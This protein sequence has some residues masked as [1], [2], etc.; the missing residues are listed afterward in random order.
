M[1]RVR[2]WAARLLWTA[3]VAVGAG[4]GGADA[5]ADAP[6]G[7]RFSQPTG[8]EEFRAQARRVPG[9]PLYF[10]DGDTPLQDD[11]EL[12]DFYDRYVR[13]GALTINEDQGKP[14]RWGEMQK[15]HLTYCVSTSF[16]PAHD[17][18]AQELQDAARAWE[19][20]AG[21]RFVHVAS[22]DGT[23]TPLNPHVVF[24]VRPAPFGTDPNI[25]AA[26]FFPN[27]VRGSRTV[28]LNL[29]ARWTPGAPP[30]ETG[31]LRHELGHV[32]GFR[33]EHVRP[34]AGGLCP[35]VHDWL[36]L[37]P[38]DPYSVMHYPSCNGRGDGWLTLTEEDVAGAREVYGPPA[39][40]LPD[41]PDTLDTSGLD[42]GSPQ[43]AQ[44]WKRRCIAGDR[45]CLERE[46]W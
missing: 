43:P 39:T 10:V 42:Q 30:T 14:T 37:T 45:E 31:V 7:P 46:S 36:P 40:E 16:G 12:R 33:H 41:T 4:C 9:S 25:Y 19:G 28:W 5:L 38:Y 2:A 17:R 22:Q 44:L 8:F 34:E 29:R 6:A 3:L 32:L 18:V 1:G 11:Q 20:A 26:S 15:M 27:Y 13:P 23:C 21:V 24:D 35:E